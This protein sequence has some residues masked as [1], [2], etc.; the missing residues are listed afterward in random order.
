MT[1]LLRLPDQML[2]TTLDHL[3]SP[4]SKVE[5]AAFLFA[6]IREDEG[7]VFEAEAVDLL[8][9]DAFTSRSRYY[10][11]LSDETR[12]RLIRKA[13]DLDAALVEIHSHPGQQGACFSWSDL[14]GFDEFVPH[15]LWRLTGRPYA[16]IVVTADG[17]LDA[18]AWRGKG[19]TAEQLQ[20]VVT[21]NRAI[22]TTGLTKANWKE[23]Y[24]DRP[25]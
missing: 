5:E 20:S 18:V 17:S 2:K 24:D 23:I 8:A 22:C 21:E 16:A 15:V 11:E 9:P 7:L 14:H 6:R 13:H 12:A 19:C 10:L 3:L 25:L 4:G 1:I